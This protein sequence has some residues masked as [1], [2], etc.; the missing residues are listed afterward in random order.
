MKK[1][2]IYIDVEDDI[3][4][5]IG[6]VKDSK[7]KIVALV[8]PKR[9][10]VLQSAV[11]LRLLQRAADQSDKRLVLIT[12]NQA[13][14]GLAAA[15][16]IPVARTLQSK[17]ELAEIPALDVD[18]GEDVI[19]GA[20]LPVG[21]HASQADKEEAE[22]DLIKGVDVEKEAPVEPAPKKKKPAGKRVPDFNSFRK[23]LIIGIIAGVL[24]IG[25][26]IWAIFFAP[27]ATIVVTART[28]DA[29]VN[30]IATF[31]AETN[32][33][34]GV[35]RATPQTIEKDVSLDF[36]AT[37]QKDVGEKATG[38]VKISKLTQNDYG[39]PAGTRITVSGG[40]VFVT[41]AAATIPAS[42][43]CFPSYCAKS[44]TV[45][46]VAEESGESYNG[47]AGTVNGPGDTTVVFQGTS[48]GSSKIVTIVTDADVQAAKEKLV[49]Q[50]TDDV[51]KELAGK[52][53]NAK[54]ID[55]SFAADYGAVTSSIA[56]GAEA[57]DKKATLAGKAKYTLTGI[58][59]DELTKYLQ[60]TI[61]KQMLDQTAQKI[62]STGADGVK[63][64]DYTRDGD[65][66]S[67]RIIATGKI[68][69]VINEDKIKQQVAGKRYGDIREELTSIDGVSD[70]DVKFSH[71]W[72]RKVP[73]KVNKITV[74]FNVQN[75]SK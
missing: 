42:T 58:E 40:R 41:Q 48:G 17:P 74:E 6:K 52:F 51:K 65:A 30:D 59:N 60:Q 22:E 50:P 35:I 49:A 7:E 28:T 19:D 71:F 39:V 14:T 72:V 20:Q 33:D 10:G 21:E 54:V 43:P 57:P 64:S 1:D 73:K 25:G 12:G 62:Y 9:I 32:V 61:K 34:K 27:A 18:N 67:V 23:K 5:I 29:S 69:P 24:L 2:I 55:A 63:L 11:N 31:G 16:M 68:G 3:T 47:V 37:G 38:T 75:A 4:A 15:A 13:L 36:T 66:Q 26:L 46:V 53:G 45:G 8:P 44:A 56:V 70:V